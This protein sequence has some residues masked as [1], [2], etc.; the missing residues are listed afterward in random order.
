MPISPDHLLV[1]IA[2]A[3]SHLSAW[4]LGRTRLLTQAWIAIARIEADTRLR[5][6]AVSVERDRLLLTARDRLPGCTTANPVAR[7]LGGTA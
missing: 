3:V 5:L 6:H 7:P 4:S 2:L 1:L